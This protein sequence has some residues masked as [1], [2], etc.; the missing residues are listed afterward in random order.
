DGHIAA[1]A[2]V[3]AKGIR[4]RPLA[5]GDILYV[6]GNSGKLSAFALPGV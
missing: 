6:Y 3:D 2:R 4:E 1:R 5:S